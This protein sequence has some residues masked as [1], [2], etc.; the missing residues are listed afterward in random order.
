M[1]CLF[2]IDFT[3]IDPDEALAAFWEAT[4][5]R[6]SVRGYAET[7]VRGVTAHRDALDEAINGALDNW[8]PERVGRIERNAI[9]VALFEMRHLND[10]PHGVAVNEAI[11]VA[12]RFGADDAPR[13]VNAVLDR[14][15]QE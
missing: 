15:K 14:L 13:F 5:A 10:V 7:L 8:S 11:E 3:G 6:A 12:K 4:P 9:R 2:G 1:Q